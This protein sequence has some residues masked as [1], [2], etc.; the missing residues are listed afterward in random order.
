MKPEDRKEVDR[1]RQ[2][3]DL[4]RA[5]IDSLE[6]Q[7][8]ERQ[9]LL[10]SFLE[11][12]GDI[13]FFKDR[14]LVYRIVNAA[15]CDSAG[16]SMEEIVGKTDH[17]LF[18]ATDADAYI[19]SDREVMR[20]RKAEIR[21][22][23]ISGKT[24]RLWLHSRK[25]PVENEAGDIIGVVCSVRDITRGKTAEQEFQRLFELVPDMV[26]SSNSAG[27]LIKV[28]A[29][30]QETLGYTPDELFSIPYADLVHPDDRDAT[31]RELQQILSGRLSRSF[32]NR[33][34]AK[35][36]SW[37]WLEW[38]TNYSDGEV[39][40]SIARD[41]T[42][43]IRQEQETRLWADAF[44]YCSHGIAIGLPSSNCILTCNEAFARM[45][46]L[47][48]QEIEGAPILRMYVPEEHERV[49]GLLREADRKGFVSYESRMVRSDGK[50]IPVQMDIVSVSDDQGNPLYRIA[51]MQDITE[52]QNSQMALIESEV[53]FR[54]A[55]ESAPEGIFI[56]IR[57]N[58]VYLNP[59]AM[60]MFGATTPG[61]LVGS[62][63]L[64]HVHP[65]FKKII[66][67]RI[68]TVN[69]EL[70]AVPLLEEKMLRLDGTSFDA[71]I[72]AVPFV[73]DSGHGALV[74]IRDITERK[75]AEKER[76]GLE[77]QLFQS[78]KLESIGR[79]A[80]GVAHDLNNL[81]TPILGY[82]E[83]LVNKLAP[84]D[85]R[86]Q[87]LKVMHDAALKARDLIRQ[88]LAFSS[89]QALEFRM[90]DLNAVVRG[91]EPL[92][93]R[94]IRA[95]VG[96]SYHFDEKELSMIGDAGQIE[97]IIMNLAINADDSMPS[98][99]KLMIETRETV[100]EAGK[101]PLFEG[102]P[103][104]RYVVLSVSDNGDG[105]D[106]ETMSQMFE[107]F[108]TTKPIGKGT[109]LG[110][111]TVYGI[112]KQH[113]GYIKVSSEPGNGACFRI[114]FPLRA[115]EICGPVTAKVPPTS[116]KSSGNV[117]VVED[118]E[119][120]RQF[121]EQSLLMEGFKVCSAASG[122]EAFRM[123]VG[124]ICVPDLLLTDLVMKGI[125]GKELFDKAAQMLPD[126]KVI[127]MSGYT[128]NIISNHGKM[129]KGVAFLQKPF[130]V[131]SL[132]GK[133]REMIKP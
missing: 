116:G 67:E 42:E 132:V 84:E 17:D 74:F 3:L 5:R 121:V 91:F 23:E 124:K 59:A 72:T 45:H 8:A 6:Q 51:T 80:G 55:V 128:N 88:L 77:K 69:N 29:A 71:E 75:L 31:L 9:E 53:R 2:E 22:W 89:S 11:V 101:E 112:V 48:V 78:Q 28:N 129:N 110:L 1:L 70:L 12:T 62:P 123:L 27:A 18:H 64:N 24:G 15:F 56:Q 118:D 133:V 44:R 21:D 57:G 40:Y 102:V 37:H 14:D 66:A 76:S 126:L 95:N 107:P 63:V 35:D 114:Y 115:G 39:L 25:F 58:F 131:R 119:L 83:I 103:A 127:Y 34:K 30:W 65:D 96:I 82:S 94:T 108:F 10:G 125:N 122:E 87:N 7:L 79:L 49:V 111:S 100:V 109:G 52:R 61:Q 97:Q 43:R 19:D 32:V 36:G 38:N 50:I 73:Y 81:L 130:S 104:G 99:G 106:G 46:R 105:M 92:L 41:I 93:R 113:G 68:R 16:M 13:L 60:K 47:T 90:F 98:G 54:S 117:L 85:A 120:V 33:Y 4:A 86:R 20:T 26:A